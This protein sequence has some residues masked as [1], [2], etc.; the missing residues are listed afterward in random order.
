MVVDIEEG[1]TG[2]RRYGFAFGSDS[3]L[4][5][6]L[7]LEQR[8]FDYTDWPESFEEFITMKSFRGAGQTLKVALEPGTV[9]SSYSITLTEPYLND[10]PTSLDIG[11]SSWERWQES[12]DE[13]KTKGFIGLEKEAVPSLDSPI[14]QVVTTDFELVS[15]L[16]DAEHDAFF[17]LRVQPVPKGR[18][19][20][21]PVEGFIVVDVGSHDTK[22]RVLF[23]A[24][25]AC[26]I[27][28]LVIQEL[29]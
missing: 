20:V 9:E 14:C 8:N 15:D 1:L 12:H 28:R 24:D 6:Q 16:L 7:G 4:I 29:L 17:V 26:E 22:F 21:H 27:D 11:G 3:G 13:Q 25:I 2:I 23:F 10:K 5:G 19:E 18:A